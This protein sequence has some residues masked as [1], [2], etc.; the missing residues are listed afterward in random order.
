MEG[1][2]N[3]AFE[4]AAAQGESPVLLTGPSI[5]PFVRSIIERFRAFAIYA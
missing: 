3:R 4:E 2:V 1:P 5:R